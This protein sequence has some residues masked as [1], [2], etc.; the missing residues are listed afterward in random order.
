MRKICCFAGHSNIGYSEKIQKQVYDKAHELAVDFGINE[1]WVGNYG[2][3]DRLATQ[4]ISIL[5]RENFDVELN[6]VIPYVTK[7]INKYKKLYY[8]CYDNILMA[9][10][11]EKTPRKYQIL[12]CNQYMVD[13]SDYLISYV[14]HS[15]GGAYR[16]LEHARRKKHIKIF[17]LGDLVVQY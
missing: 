8:D 7:E 11:P 12:K 4:V 15:Y 13:K 14:N 5:K 6:L 16:T 17:N 1:F 9:D 2:G 3:F 10:I